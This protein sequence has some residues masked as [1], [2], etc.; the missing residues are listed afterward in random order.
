MKDI[1]YLGKW[2]MR[3]RECVQRWDLRETRI[4][5]ARF[6]W[7]LMNEHSKYYHT[8]KLILNALF[9]CEWVN[10]L[11]P[12]EIFVYIKTEILKTETEFQFQKNV[13]VSVVCCLWNWK[14]QSRIWRGMRFCE[15]WNV[16]LRG[17]LWST[18]SCEVFVMGRVFIF[19]CI[20]ILI[21]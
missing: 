14:H 6:S 20:R 10:V 5:E 15:K 1:P 21:F 9:Q 2:K 12:V 17:T 18:A 19:E 16:V 7:V 3:K 13:G 4:E 11:M 8:K